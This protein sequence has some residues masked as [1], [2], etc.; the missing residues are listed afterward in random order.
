MVLN[1]SISQDKNL[2]VFRELENININ[3]FFLVLFLFQILFIFQGID[4]ADEGFHST[5]YQQIYHNPQSVEYNFMYWLSG[6]IGGAWLKLFPAYGLLGLRLGGVI[7][8]MLAI[9]LSYRLLKNYTRDA[10]LKLGLLLMVLINGAAVKD[11]NYNNISALLFISSILFIFNGLRKN[12]FSDLAFAGGFVSLAVFSRLAN[13]SGLALATVIIY[14]GF[15]VFNRSITHQVKQIISFFSGF[16]ITTILV[17]GAMKITGQYTQFIDSVKLL[18]S[19]AASGENTHDMTKLIKIITGDYTTAIFKRALPLCIFVLL[20]NI[21]LNQIKE[22]RIAHIFRYGVTVSFV[23]FLLGFILL[24][25]TITIWTFYMMLFAA[26]SL[27]ATVFLVIRKNNNDLALIGLAST[28]TTF[29]LIAGADY[30]LSASGSTALWIGMPIATDFFMRIFSLK[31][32]GSFEVQGAKD[33]NI[34]NIGIDFFV[35]PRQLKNVWNWGVYSC[36]IVLVLHTVLYTYN[37]NPNR[38]KMAYPV[39]NAFLKGAFTTGERAEAINELLEASSKYIKQDDYV[40]AYKDIPLFYSLTQTMPFIKNS[41]PSLYTRSQFDY[42][43]NKA[44]LENHIL[45]PIVYQ[46]VQTIPGPLWPDPKLNNSAFDIDSPKN[47]IIK[48]FIEKYEYKS[49]WE[50]TAFRIYIADSN[51][52]SKNL[53]RQH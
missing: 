29:S 44:V 28:I 30:G 35:T 21:I 34:K 9:I 15:F 4:I 23:S 27:I 7:L 36:V 20:Y 13:I 52:I 32:D 1:G 49:I 33:P 38:M 48:K 37:D 14:S 51:A 40:I 25:G 16:I 3:F 2:Q 43:L 31:I 18:K 10:Y 53:L 5:F 17:I 8:N 26:M 12:K 6:I 41:W 50:N 11:I 46:K 39:R 22:T 19:M 47:V 24:N 45:P 42:E